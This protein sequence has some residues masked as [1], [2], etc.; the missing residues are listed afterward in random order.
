MKNELNILVQEFFKIL[1]TIEVTD[2]GREF[3]PTTISSCRTMDSIKLNKILT[4]M[5]EIVG[6]PNVA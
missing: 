6:D 4:R 2:D 1:D 5:K 3:H